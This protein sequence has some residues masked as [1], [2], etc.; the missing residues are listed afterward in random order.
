M[1]VTAAATAIPP[2]IT[3]TTTE[4]EKATIDGM[5]D[6]ISHDLDYLLNR[7]AEIPNTQVRRST[8][9]TGV[10]SKTVVDSTSTQLLAGT[11]TTTGLGD[12][13]PLPPPPPVGTLP[14]HPNLSVR[15]VILEEEAED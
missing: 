12:V 14:S 15:E 10:N 7:T 13:V 8:A 6:R 5:L 11:S 3:I 9:P 4:E 2:T 1:M